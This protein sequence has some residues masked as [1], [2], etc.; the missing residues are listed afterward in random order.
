MMMATLEGDIRAYITASSDPYKSSP[1]QTDC[2]TGNTGLVLETYKLS[3]DGIV[4]TMIF[5]ID[6]LN[7]Y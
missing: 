3:N 7:K 5:A 6:D 4:C 1:P 2:V